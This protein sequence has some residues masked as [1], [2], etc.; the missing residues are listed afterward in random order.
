VRLRERERSSGDS[1]LQGVQWHVLRLPCAPI[2]LVD[3]TPSAPT[4]A[5]HPLPQ[6]NQFYPV[7]ELPNIVKSAFDQHDLVE[8]RSAGW[9]GQVPSNGTRIWP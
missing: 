9:I 7:D 1:I 8:I 5:V 3:A 6:T 4:V 2:R